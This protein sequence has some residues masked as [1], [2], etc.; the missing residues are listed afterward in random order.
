MNVAII[1]ARGGSKRIP[2]KNIR[3]F[4]GKPMIHWSIHAAR[5]SACFDRIVVSTDDE[6]VAAQAVAA[7]AEA[8]FRRPAELA[9]DR[10]PTLPVI[11]HALRW[12][13]EQGINPRFA[14]CIYATAP[15][16]EATDLRA[17]F[18][19]L[20]QDDA[21]YVFTAA[22]FAFPPARS[23]RLDDA[24][25]AVPA[26]PEYIAS[27][28][29]D[30]PEM[31]HDAGQFYWGKAQAFLEERPIFSRGSLPFMLPRSRVQ[32]IDTQEDWDQA[33]LLFRASKLNSI[34]KLKV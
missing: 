28:S 12:L 25:F 27:R 15:F 1:P 26:F 19:K 2:R 18:D 31:F 14:C 20:A 33:Q 21:N 7:G 34:S 23:L 16:I 9:D 3:E 13:G 22:S 11:A 5:E 6:E 10:T 32:D 17:A 29:Q 30:L 24:G 8:P 4:C